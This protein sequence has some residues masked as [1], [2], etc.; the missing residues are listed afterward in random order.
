MTITVEQIADELRRLSPRKLAQVYDFVLRLN[1]K[2][3]SGGTD[4]ELDSLGEV[5]MEQYL[6]GLQDYEERLARGEIRWE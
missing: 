1:S 6:A 5:G 3:G 2:N 4:A